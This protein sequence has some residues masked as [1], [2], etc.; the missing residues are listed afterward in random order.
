MVTSKNRQ[1][2]IVAALA[3][4]LAC[5]LATPSPAP[6]P[7]LPTPTPRL[8][9]LPPTI[10]PSPT[11][12]PTFDW[13][14][15]SAY[16]TAMLPSFRGDLMAFAQVTRYAIDLTVNPEDALVVGHQRVLYTNT[17]GVPLNDVY[18]RFF[19]NTPGYG[20][21]ATVNRLLV[22]SQPAHMTTEL[23]NSALRVAL[24]A[25][26][27][28]GEQV[29]FALDFQVQ[30]PT[31]A[32]EGYGQLGIRDGVVALAN[33]YPVIPVYDDEGWN[34]ELAPPYGDATYTD[35]ALY[36]VHC[37]APVGMV[38]AASG[39][40]VD[41]VDNGDGTATWTFVSGPMRDF[42]LIMSN[43]FQVISTTVGE[44]TVNSYFL[45]TDAAGGQRALDYASA[46]LRVYNDRFG[47]Y[48]FA[49]F[50][51]VEVPLNGAGGIEYPGLVVIDRALYSQERGYFE[52]ATVHET[53][54]QWW[55]SLVGNDQ[56]DEP[57]LDEAL[58]N[59]SVV[60]YFEKVYGQKFAEMFV[61]DYFVHNYDEIVKA[62]RDEIVGR[63]VA[64]FSEEQ[65]GPIVYV[66]GPLFFHYLRQ[67]VGDETFFAI[68]RTYFQRYRYDIATPQGFLAVANEVSGQDITPLY[69]KWILSAEP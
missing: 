32:E 10:T 11:A 17:E 26:L 7:V 38:V 49:E 20:G 30:L 18:F 15:L 37:T 5:T 16:E 52:H 68:L 45:P 34:V 50:D 53:A 29:D 25:P 24:P 13:G 40:Q 27:L 57:W 55:Y 8:T 3:L 63:P 44:V 19:P 12:W 22:N 4:A 36:Q 47:P 21:T 2:I 6:T 66:K 58:T 39:S 31:K 23:D 59:Y 9:S 35:T 41:W 54:H 69:E 62:G 61:E 14:S 46:A 42:N 28:P 1:L 67:Q 60:V 43:D 56:L 33:V 48:P 65:Y 51:V 64:E